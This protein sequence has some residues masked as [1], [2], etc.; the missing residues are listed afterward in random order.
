MRQKPYF[1]SRRTTAFLT[2][3][4][5]LM[6]YS[7][8]G[9]HALSCSKGPTVAEEFERSTV[10]FR[11]TVVKENNDKLTFQVRESWKGVVG[12]WIQVQVSTIWI[13]M[14][15][16]QEYLVYATDQSGKLTA[17]LCGRTDLWEK[18]K[19][20]VASFPN[21]STFP[22]PPRYPEL[23]WGIPLFASVV[24]LSGIG[25][26]LYIRYARNRRP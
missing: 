13:P 23:H 7:P 15:R 17:N 16:G 14:Q 6:A 2:L 10:V 22:A 5:L 3:L 25:A 21:G 9:V 8:R 26:G 4:L 19:L 24:T 1:F 12:S 11:G 20:D 18:S